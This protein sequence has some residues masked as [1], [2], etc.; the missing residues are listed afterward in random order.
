[1][2]LHKAWEQNLGSEGENHR[3]QEQFNTPSRTQIALSVAV[4]YAIAKIAV[5]IAPWTP[6]TS[7]QDSQATDGGL[8]QLSGLQT[9]GS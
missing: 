4:R 6:A 2:L 8:I 9:P 7:D 5:R 1:V 3:G